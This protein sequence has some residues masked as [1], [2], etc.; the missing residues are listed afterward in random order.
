MNKDI[1]N[2][3]YEFW[4]Y[5][6]KTMNRLVEKDHYKCVSMFDS[7]WPNRIFSLGKIDMSKIIELSQQKLLP[8]TI[9]IPQPNSL[10]DHLHTKLLFKQRNM[11]LD[12]KKVKKIFKNDTNI[13]Q[14]RTREDAFKFAKTA[15]AAFGYKVDGHVACSISKDTSKIQLFNYLKHNECLG[16]GIVFFD[17]NNNAGLHMIGT[18]PNARGKGIGN[19]LTE[20]LLYVAKSNNNKYCVLNASTMGENI[21]KELGFV[22]FRELETYLILEKFP[23]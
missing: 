6:G 18:M 1:L 3:L 15:S 14:I 13:K 5:I 2:N 11:A 17:S 23:N 19:K 10:G 16:C 9:T 8:N 4:E 21:Y 20:K 12:L 7:D 22:S